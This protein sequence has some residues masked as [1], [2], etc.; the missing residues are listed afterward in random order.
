[1]SRELVPFKMPLKGQHGL[2]LQ[3]LEN[4]RQPS[5]RSEMDHWVQYG[6]LTERPA[7][8]F[9]MPSDLGQAATIL[10][11]DRIAESAS[12]APAA[13]IALPRCKTKSEDS[14]AGGTAPAVT[15]D[16]EQLSNNFARL[17]EQGCKAIAACLKPENRRLFRALQAEKLQAGGTMVLS[18]STV[19]SSLKL[20]PS[21]TYRNSRRNA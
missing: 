18:L 10:T 2:P 4:E 9:A 16:I 21:T 3:R 13:D 15:I 8:G 12:D 5:P 11:R 6:R 1:V 7:P 17:S 14:G 19:S 20:P